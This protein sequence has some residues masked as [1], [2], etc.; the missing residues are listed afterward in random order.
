[1][2]SPDADPTDYLLSYLDDA[3]R[4]DLRLADE[5]VDPIRVEA[6]MRAVARNVSTEVAVPKL[7]EQAQLHSQH[8]ASLSEK[9]ARKYLDAMER[10]FVLEEQLAWST[11]RR[12]KAR[13][14]VHPKW[15]FIDPSLAT[16]ALQASPD[17]LLNDL[18]TMGFLFE[19]LAIPGW[20]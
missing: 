20:K 9:T 10:I 5:R 19:S 13:L 18:N 16:A 6:L 12:S 7:S 14:R 1:M 2:N 8:S 11:H 17:A 4:V 15:H 3:A